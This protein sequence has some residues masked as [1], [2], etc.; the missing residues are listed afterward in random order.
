MFVIL[1]RAASAAPRWLNGEYLH[2][3]F[4]WGAHHIANTSDDYKLFP[5]HEIQNAPS[6]F[7]FAPGDPAEMPR[8]SKREN[9]Q[10]GL[11]R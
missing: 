5:Y 3:Y 7:N 8:G 2:R 11:W 10:T 9:S 1:T 4:V 6:A